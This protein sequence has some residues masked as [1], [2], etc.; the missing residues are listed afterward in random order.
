LVN[1]STGTVMSANSV[2]VEQLAIVLDWL[3]R[4]RPDSPGSRFCLFRIA[5]DHP[6]FLGRTFG[7]SD[8]MRRLKQFGA[9]L[10]ST[11]RRTDLL[12]RDLS[13]FWILMPDCNTEAVHARLRDIVAQ[14]EALGLD[15]VPCSI[16]TFVFPPGQAGVADARA[17]LERLASEPGVQEFGPAPSEFQLSLA[18]PA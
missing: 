11:V 17:L 9:V 16:G 18:F 1:F 3:I 7:A 14:V 2:S 10:A 5:F 15:V 8:A 6:Q 12:A 4:Q 13:V